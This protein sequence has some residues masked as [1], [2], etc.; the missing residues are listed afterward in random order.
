MVASKSRLLASTITRV[1]NTSPLPSS[2]AVVSAGSFDPGDSGEGGRV[3]SHI[4]RPSSAGQFCN[5]HLSLFLQ[6]ERH[7]LSDRTLPVVLSSG[8]NAS[9]VLFD[10]DRQALWNQPST[11]AR[12]S[13][14]VLCMDFYFR[15][16][17]TE[18]SVSRG[19]GSRG[20]A[21]SAQLLLACPRRSLHCAAYELSLTLSPCLEP[22]TV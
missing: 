21:Q 20:E 9:H 16:E 11:V 17:N 6:L 22:P 10:C 7:R 15:V 1:I 13:A 5:V 18:G 14:R 2:L 12:P 8:P 4:P 19:G 3:E